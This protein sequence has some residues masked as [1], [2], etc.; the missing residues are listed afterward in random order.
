[1]FPFIAKRRRSATQLESILRKE[2]DKFIKIYKR[3]PSSREFRLFI[4]KINNKLDSELN[5]AIT[6]NLRQVW[7][8]EKSSVAREL[9]V[10]LSVNTTDLTAFQFMTNRKVF[11]GAIS[12]LREKTV[13]QLQEV[14]EETLANPD[15]YNLRELQGKIRNVAQTSDFRAET[16]ARTETN[17]ISIASRRVSYLQADPTDSF[18]YEHKGPDDR[19]TTDTSKRIK[20]RTRGGVSWQEYV[21]IVTEESAKDFPTWRVNPL[22]PSS[23]WNSRHSP[24][25]VQ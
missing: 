14:F 5:S 3:K 8:R 21:K 20:R 11:L 7:G 24:V 22:A 23:H 17:N 25:R 12:S 18:R 13:N 6:S 10:Q 2:L 1:M 4:R 19:R 15:G 9:G 16:I